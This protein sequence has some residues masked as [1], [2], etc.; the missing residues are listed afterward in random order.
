MGALDEDLAELGLAAVA[1]GLPQLLA[2]AEKGG[3]GYEAFL[4]SVVAHER[5]ERAA[6][7]QA[8]LTRLARFP[9]P[10]TLAGFDMA[11]S[12]TIDAGLIR[13]L[14]TLRFIREQANV[15]LLGPPGVGKTHLAIALGMEA[16]ARGMKSYFTTLEE[17]ISRLSAGAPALL[18]RRM[19]RYLSCQLLIIDEVGYLPLT[20]AQAHLLFQVIS[21]RYESGST[22]I[23]SNKP[24]V[25]WGDYLSDPTLAAAL[26]DRFLHHCH[27][28]SITGAS[29]RLKDKMDL[30]A[31]GKHG[32]APVP[33]TRHRTGK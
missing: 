16:V 30:V 23:T 5:A 6:S 27:V 19:T 26:L 22:I 8:I 9:Q 7:R 12:P 32:A 1:S 24:V 15:L 25:E 17:L 11:F 28:V 33:A 29:Y 14:A 10:K 20:A 2:A 3:A 13:E 4:A 31:Q 21:S 18:A